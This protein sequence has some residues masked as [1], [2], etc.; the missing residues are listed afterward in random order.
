MR[1]FDVR[2]I[3][4]GSVIVGVFFG[5]SVI[6]EWP[7]SQFD[8]SLA[9]I[10]A[11]IKEKNVTMCARTEVKKLLGLKSG[12]EVMDAISQRLAPMNCHYVG[13]VVGQQ[14]Y[15]K[16]QDVENAIS[17]CNRACDSACIHGVIGAVFAEALG[18]SGLEDYADIDVKHLNPDDIRTV[19][20][21][22]CSTLGTC[23]GV[24]H[25]L[26]QTYQEIEPAFA[27]CREIA[28]SMLNQ[29]Y[30]GVT[31]EYADILSSRGM[32][33]L[34]GIEYPDPESL[35]SF[36]DFPSI[37]ESHACFR[38]FPRVVTVTLRRQGFSEK[39]SIERVRNICESY[40]SVDMRIACFSGM[41]STG[42]YLLLTDMPAA[43]KFCEE[44]GNPQAEA[45]CILGRISVATEDRAEKIAAYCAAIH[46][47][48]MKAI[49]YQGLFFNLNRIN[50]SN[51]EQE[52]LCKNDNEL[53]EQGRKD[54]KIGPMEKVKNLS[55]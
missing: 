15:V 35:D 8:S 4:L 22:L 27:L 34:S 19:G 13:H 6:K 16:L 42:S 40:K 2:G 32:G 52:A 23:H 49:C 25:A 30:N 33:T 50:L 17:Q 11:C 55:R 46:D 47:V 31:M 21:R 41:G 9:R 43:V 3:L 20:R 5:V 26:F 54:R 44:L 18:F 45:S 12:A 39:E 48:S 28:G 14:L 53:C 38:Y 10:S 24:G 51:Q 1:F 29:C 7:S 37:I 36:C